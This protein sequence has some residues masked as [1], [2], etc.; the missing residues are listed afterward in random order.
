MKN[1]IRKIL[2]EETENKKHDI[3]NIM[4]VDTYEE[5]IKLLKKYL[6]SIKEN[7]E[8]WDEIKKPLKMWKEATDE[9]R[10]EIDEDGMTG[11]SEVDESDTW[12]ATIQSSFCK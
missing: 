6:G 1:I 4:T 11:D 9:I 8:A 10:K 7:P 5:G 3:C 12:W 2:K